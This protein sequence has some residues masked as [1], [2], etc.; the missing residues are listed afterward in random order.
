[1]K[2]PTLQTQSMGR[3]TAGLSLFSNMLAEILDPTDLTEFTIGSVINVTTSVISNPATDFI[4]LVGGA[5]L[6]SKGFLNE[7]K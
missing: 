6:F 1:M 7:Q 5:L 4:G 2:M 3:L